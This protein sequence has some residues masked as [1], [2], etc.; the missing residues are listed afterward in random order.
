MYQREG[1]FD[2]LP[3]LIIPSDC[4][5]YGASSALVDMPAYRGGKTIPGLA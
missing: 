4:V 1:C 3:L 5:N 2:L